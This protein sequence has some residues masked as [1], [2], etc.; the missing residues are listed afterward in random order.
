[1]K[2]IA[3]C[4][5]AAGLGIAQD[6]S[7]DADHSKADHSKASDASAGKGSSEAKSKNESKGGGDRQHQKTEPF[8]KGRDSATGQSSGR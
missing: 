5:L 6:K 2:V 4:L 8:V 7:R 3:I 1:M